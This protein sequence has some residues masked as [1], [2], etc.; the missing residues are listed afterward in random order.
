MQILGS[1]GNLREYLGDCT[2]KPE[3][4]TKKAGVTILENAD[5]EALA[6]RKVDDQCEKDPVS[7][8]L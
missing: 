4:K 8:R 3:V 2:E 6:T 5:G 7:E 1:T